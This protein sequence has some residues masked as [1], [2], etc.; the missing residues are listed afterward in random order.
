MKEQRGKFFIIN[1]L[2][3]RGFKLLIPDVFLKTHY[4]LMP[5]GYC[6]TFY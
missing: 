5:N 6:L 4:C 1:N 3:L 2:S